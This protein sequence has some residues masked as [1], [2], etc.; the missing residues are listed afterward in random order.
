MRQAEGLMCT[1]AGSLIY[2]R[3]KEIFHKIKCLNYMASLRIVS[4]HIP[5]SVSRIFFFISSMAL[6][7]D[8]VS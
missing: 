6:F 8:E 3:V 1:I 5:F 4:L 2:R 7:T